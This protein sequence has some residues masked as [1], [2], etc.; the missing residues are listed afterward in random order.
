MAA[1]AQLV[2]E[3]MFFVLYENYSF[4]LSYSA[5][6]EYRHHRPTYSPL[7]RTGRRLQLAPVGGTRSSCSGLL[8]AKESKGPLVPTFVDQPRPQSPAGPAHVR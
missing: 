5:W 8:A 7:G 2:P 4:L 3:Y 6:T 1:K